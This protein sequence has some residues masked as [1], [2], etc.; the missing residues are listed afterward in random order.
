MA[1]QT[2]LAAP[3]RPSTTMVKPLAGNDGCGRAK[4][5]K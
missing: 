4:I 5:G 2:R 3:N 1:Q